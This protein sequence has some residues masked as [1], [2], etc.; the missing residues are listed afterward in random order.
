MYGLR[1]LWLNLEI[2]PKTLW[3]NMGYWSEH[4][5]HYSEAC[6]RLVLMVVDKLNI[7]PKDSILDVG[8]GCGDS[9][10]FL[11]DRFDCQVTGITN[12]YAQWKLSKDRTEQLSRK[13]QERIKLF[14]GSATELDKVLG[15]DG[16]TD[17]E[18]DHIVS[19]DSAYH[20]NTR[21][22]FLR[23]AFQH[24]KPGG[25]LGLYDIV[26]HEKAT[27][28]SGWKRDVWNYISTV[29]HLPLA[30]METQENYG[31]YL[32]Q[33]GYVDIEFEPLLAQD[34]FGGLSFYCLEQK[35]KMNYWQIGNW[36]DM[37]YLSISAFLFDTL[38]KKQWL[39]PMI[40]KASSSKCV[41][42]S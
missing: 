7:K 24:L 18:F 29:L 30:N 34:V 12:E 13:Q 23:Q 42:Y 26:L 31:A 3:C 5:N 27:L 6:E 1:H 14:E 28:P 17:L 33:Y 19:I 20:F 25:T 35:N 9:C 10:L 16:K 2:P 36:Q 11:A 38:A 8:Y 40:I 39:Q 32:K 41:G 21:W 15:K 22:D 4:V 37:M